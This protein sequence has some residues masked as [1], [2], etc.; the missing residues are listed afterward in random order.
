M[1]V[2]L[3]G[4]Y[5]LPSTFTSRLLLNRSGCCPLSAKACWQIDINEVDVAVEIFRHR[6]NV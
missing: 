4:A 3:P 1:T 2:H 5:R 6:I